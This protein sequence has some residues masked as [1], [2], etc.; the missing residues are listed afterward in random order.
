MNSKIWKSI[1]FLFALMNFGTAHSQDAN[2][3]GK[4][5]SFPSEDGLKITADLY[6]NQNAKAPLI[7]LFHQAGYSRGEYRPIAPMLNEMGFSCLAIDQRSGAGVNDVLNE[8]NARATAKKMPTEYIDALPDLEAALD[9]AQATISKDIIIWG[10]SYSSALVVYLGAEHGEE[11][12]GILAFSPGEYFSIHG[13]KFEDYAKDVKA[14]FFVT[15][16]KN[17]HDNWKGI[18]ANIPG[19]KAYYLPSD[20]GFHGSRALWPTN[21]GHEAC[22]A[23]VTKFLEGLK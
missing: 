22:W 2:F 18:Y 13:K 6:L 15:S 12:K 21:A 20:P 1:C 7:I 10:S 8:T 3:T 17:E 4:E 9:F 23:E 5:I 11:L 16:A 14:P 19:E